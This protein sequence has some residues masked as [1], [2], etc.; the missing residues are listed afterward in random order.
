[1]KTVLKLYNRFVLPAFLSLFVLRAGGSW[2]YVL[3]RRKG[4]VTVEFLLMLSMAA[5]MAII[6]GVLFHKKL[7]GG[8]FTVV[9]MI[10]GG[11]SPT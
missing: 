8:F 7:L 4:Q 5:G 1:M 11:G 2:S 9:G 6:G 3:K 10:I